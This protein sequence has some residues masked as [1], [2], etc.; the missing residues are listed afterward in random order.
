MPYARVKLV[1]NE[2]TLCSPTAKQMSMTDPSVFRRSAAAR[3]RR[4]VNRYEWGA[5]PKV[6]RNSRL[7]WAREK[8]AARAR[9]STPNGSKYRASARS[10]AR[11]RSRGR[12]TK[13]TGG[14]SPLLLAGAAGRDARRLVG[15]LRVDGRPR[16]VHEPV[17]AV[18]RVHG[19]ERLQRLRTVV[20]V[21]PGIAVRLDPGRERGDRQL[22]GMDLVDLLP[23]QRCRH[24]RAEAGAY[25][26]RAEHRLVRRVL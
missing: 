2:P 13:T 17:G 20:H 10:L 22:V 3:S 4:R 26:P 1:V 19:E 6:R 5:S 24:L 15:L 25:R 21:G 7:K 14:E 11:S 16:R 8:P 9:S 18:L 12:D 23:V